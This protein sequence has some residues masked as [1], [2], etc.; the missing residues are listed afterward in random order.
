MTGATGR[1]L[2]L[3]AA[4]LLLSLLLSGCWDAQPIER[5]G[6]IIAMGFDVAEN[7]P[8][9]FVLT[10]SI[11]LFQPDAQETVRTNTV[12]AASVGQAFDIWQ[13]QH[14][15][16][17]APGKLR[18]VI[19]SE[20]VARRNLEGLITLLELPRVNDNAIVLITKESPEELLRERP[21]ANPRV[22]AYMAQFIEV[23]RGEGMLLSLNISQVLT[24][25]A[26]PDTDAFLPI[27]LKDPLGEA[28]YVTGTALFSDLTMVGE[29]DQHETQL[30]MALL[31]QHARVNYT[32]AVGVTGELYN[33]YP[34]ITFVRPRMNCRVRY[35]GE[36]LHVQVTLTSDYTMRDYRTP[37]DLTESDVVENINRDIESNLI[38]EIERLL[39]KFQELQTDPLGIGQ[40]VR[41]QENRNFDADRFKEDWQNAAIEVKAELSLTRPSTLLKTQWDRGR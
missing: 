36:R 11:P 5:L 15:V 23:M 8:N 27:V 4:M 13:T 9:L 22:G 3:V 14:N 34:Y 28:L 17:F 6:L 21:L 38:I 29:L 41:I 33:T 25:A 16:I 19:L 7:N 24:R 1:L 12:T 2:R 31:G 40:R 30:L 18:V 10:T 39:A 35:E 26:T 37:G 32:P 20:E